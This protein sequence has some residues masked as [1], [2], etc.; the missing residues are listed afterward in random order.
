MHTAAQHALQQQRVTH[1]CRC[2]TACSTAGGVLS[3]WRLESIDTIPVLMSAKS[4]AHLWGASSCRLC[5]VACR[6][7]GGQCQQR[8]LETVSIQHFHPSEL[9]SFAVAVLLSL[10]CCV[11]TGP[12]QAD[13]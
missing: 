3:Y 7:C 10:C 2:C 12:V 11:C 8:T 13:G 6:V 1:V 9:L 4:K 5:C